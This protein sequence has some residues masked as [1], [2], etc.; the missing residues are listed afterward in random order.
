MVSEG[1][2]RKM[3]GSFADREDTGATEELMRLIRTALA[4]QVHM[5]LFPS[6]LKT[7]P[8]RRPF[9]VIGQY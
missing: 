1:G 3:L 2:K 5:T 7:G 8:C 4:E 6:W 9:S